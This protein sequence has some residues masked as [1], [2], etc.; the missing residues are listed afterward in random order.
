MAR[1]LVFIL[2]VSMATTQR[3]GNAVKD[4]G[5]YFLKIVKN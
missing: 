2:C 1:F 4:K 5:E 3:N